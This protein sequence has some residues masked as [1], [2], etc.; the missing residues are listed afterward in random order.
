ML[1]MKMLHSKT[2]K[3]IELLA[4]ETYVHTNTGILR[5]NDS[6]NLPYEI[7]ALV[8]DTRPSERPTVSAALAS[9]SSIPSTQ[10]MTKFEL[11]LVGYAWVRF[12]SS[13]FWDSFIF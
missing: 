9:S 1:L 4:S 10:V 2:A 3:I 12:I 8:N 6:N 7:R 11:K 5:H 13:A